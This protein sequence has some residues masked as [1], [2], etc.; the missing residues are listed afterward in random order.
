ML[1]FLAM[2]AGMVMVPMLSRNYCAALA[3]TRHFDGR[4]E[5]AREAGSKSS[6]RVHCN[7]GVVAMKVHTILQVISFTSR[8]QC[9]SGGSG[10]TECAPGLLNLRI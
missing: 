5:E 10:G 4:T 9:N 3:G 2:V 7:Q 6:S 1:Q 8:T